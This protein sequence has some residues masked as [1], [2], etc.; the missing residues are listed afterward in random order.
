MPFTASA[1][2]GAGMTRLTNN[3]RAD[4]DAYF[5]PDGNTIAWLQLV[6]PAGWGGVGTW[7][8]FAMDRDGNNVRA[9]I[10]DGYINSKP[11]WSLDGSRIFL[12]RLGPGS[13]G[14][15]ELF[16]VVP[17]G[18]GLQRINPIVPANLEYP[19]N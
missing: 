4:Y 3:S 19:A 7:S 1:K 2:S 13:T 15:W 17:D 5:S 10:D 14:F 11:A 8:V 9:V 12:H 16:S 18:S 6:D